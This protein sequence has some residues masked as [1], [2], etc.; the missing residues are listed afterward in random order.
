MLETAKRKI[1]KDNLYELSWA[2]ASNVV[3]VH[4]RIVSQ[5]GAVPAPGGGA[6]GTSS[7]SAAPAAPAGVAGLRGV[8]LPNL[9]VGADLQPV[10][11]VSAAASGVRR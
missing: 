5:P 7:G 3:T 4:L 1:L 9:V 2:N 8:K 10:A 11:A 6:V